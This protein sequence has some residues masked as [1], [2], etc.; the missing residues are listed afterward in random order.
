[1]NIYSGKATPSVCS[2]NNKYIFLVYLCVSGLLRKQQYCAI[3]I[4]FY[5]ELYARDLIFVLQTHFM[6]NK[7]N[8]FFFVTS[9]DG[10]TKTLNSPHVG[11]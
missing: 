10:D 6:Q 11:P 9:S 1:M 5:L 3:V 4:L 2:Y 7:Q 8:V